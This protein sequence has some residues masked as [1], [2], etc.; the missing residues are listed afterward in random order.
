M[1]YDRHDCHEICSASTPTVFSPCGEG[2]GRRGPC[3]L[4]PFSVCIS[5]GGSGVTDEDHQVS[6]RGINSTSIQSGIGSLGSP[7]KLFPCFVQMSGR[8]SALGSISTYN[9]PSHS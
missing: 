6:R 7:P 8:R 3:P 5:R 2:R 1:V 4:R 9:L